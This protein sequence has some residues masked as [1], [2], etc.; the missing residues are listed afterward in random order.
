MWKI[1]RCSQIFE[2]GNRGAGGVQP[3]ELLTNKLGVINET[4]TLVLVVKHPHE[5]YPLF[6]LGGIRQNAYFYSCGNYGRCGRI[7]F[8]ETSRGGGP[9]R[10]AAL[11]NVMVVKH[12]CK[13]PM[14]IS[15]F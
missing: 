7:S 1:Y 10:C 8:L 13:R 5:N 9:W 2:M 15:R 4:I 6:Y 14:T 12:K 3:E 11:K